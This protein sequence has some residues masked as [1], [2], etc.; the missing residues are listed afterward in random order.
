MMIDKKIENSFIRLTGGNEISPILLEKQLYII[1]K[2]VDNYKKNTLGK[3]LSKNFE[4]IIK[5]E[6]GSIIICI[7]TKLIVMALF[8]SA[9]K[10]KVY[11]KIYYLYCKKVASNG[12][13][14]KKV[15]SNNIQEKIYKLIWKDD[16]ELEIPIWL[17]NLINSEDFSKFSKKM[18]KGY[19]DE[20][21]SIEIYSSNEQSKLVVTKNN[22]KELAK[23]NIKDFE[24]KE[25]TVVT[26]HT[27]ERL[28]IT[29]DNIE[30]TES[31]QRYNLKINEKI[32]IK[33]YNTSNPDLNLLVYEHKE[34]QNY[35]VVDFTLEMIYIAA[36][37]FEYKAII[38]KV[39]KIYRDLSEEKNSPDF[40]KWMN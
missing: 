10:L 25:E 22:I 16:D 6:E 15:K 21:R 1:N 30:E 35:M 19:L 28:Y 39:H 18:F 32:K 8:E 20:E 5:I 2:I 14:I 33:N 9:K 31:I 4:V 11:I 29:K 38:H 24:L 12:K 13:P 7:I 3:N 40:W 27:K 36:D 37:K 26:E 23:N 34:N 17:Y